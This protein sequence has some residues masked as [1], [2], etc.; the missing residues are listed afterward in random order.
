MKVLLLLLAAASAGSQPSREELDSGRYVFRLKEYER[1]DPEAEFLAGKPPPVRP[2]DPE[3]TITQVFIAAF[4]ETRCG[5]TLYHLFKRAKRPHLV[6]AAITDQ[7]AP[8]DTPCIEQVQQW[9]Q[10]EEGAPFPYAKQVKVRYV[11]AERSKGPCYA[12]GLADSLVTE[13]EQ[14]FCMQIDSHMMFVQHWDE[15]TQQEWLRTENEFGVLTTYVNNIDM[16]DQKAWK[17]K[18][19]SWLP[20][21]CKT[22]KGGYG[23]VRNEQAEAAVSLKRPKLTVTWGAGF[24]FSRCHMTRTVPNDI[25]LAHIFDGEEYSRFTRM[26][27]HGYDTYTPSRNTVFHDYSP[28]PSRWESNYKGD[29]EA[30]VK[31]SLKYLAM[32][33]NMPELHEFTEEEGREAREDPVYGL[34]NCRTYEQLEGFGDT[35]TRPNLRPSHGTRCATLTWVPY[36]VKSCHGVGEMRRQQQPREEQQQQQGAI[37]AFAAHVSY[38]ESPPRPSTY[39]WVL[40][41]AY[42]MFFFYVSFTEL[43]REKST[44]ASSKVSVA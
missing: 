31:D 9:W 27:T 26:W 10:R 36:D 40:L 30:E 7:L 12:R 17:S 39:F 14:A 23:S 20:H 32:L 2:Y 33:W 16:L 5:R 18:D 41:W 19:D 24:S 15:Q 22:M 34:G 25:R 29:R 28:V 35:R 13:E 6:H 3:S 43:T 42:M 11:Q 8:G 21:I 37:P 4:R 44:R 1:F 38:D